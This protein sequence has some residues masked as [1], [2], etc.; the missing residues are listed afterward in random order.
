M[1]SMFL[2]ISD[3]RFLPLSR[4]GPGQRLRRGQQPPTGE[5]LGCEDGS[6]AFQSPGQIDRA[7]IN[8]PTHLGT[9]SAIFRSYLWWGLSWNTTPEFLEVYQTNTEYVST[10]GAD[11][12]MHDLE[13]SALQAE[14]GAEIDNGV[15]LPLAV[16]LHVSGGDAQVAYE[17]PQHLIANVGPT[18][19]FFVLA[20]RLG[21][22]VLQLS[23]QGGDSL[24]ATTALGLLKQRHHALDT[25]VRLDTNNASRS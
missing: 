10:S 25:I 13:A 2:L 14:T 9:R 22:Y 12:Y 16:P 24:D 11:D 17:V 15:A 23:V 21:R 5:Q 8:M 4:T 20:I 6:P 7:R 1:R 18:E 19:R 3:S